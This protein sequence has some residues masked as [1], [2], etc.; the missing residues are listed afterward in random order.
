MLKMRA[1]VTAAIATI[2]AVPAIAQERRPGPY[3]GIHPGATLTSP[4][5]A[6]LTG[7]SQPTRCDSLLYSNGVPVATDCP[8]SSPREIY[9]TDFDLGTGYIGSVQ[10]GYGW[11]RLRLEAEYVVRF[12]GSSSAP[13][14][15]TSDFVA[16]GKAREWNE[17]APPHARVS[18]LRAHQIFANIYYDFANASRWTPYAGVGAGIARTS[19]AYGNRYVR[20]TLAQGFHPTGGVDPTTAAA[21]PEWQRNS[22]GTVSAIEADVSDTVLGFQLLGGLDYDLTDRVSVGAQVRWSRFEPIT[23]E[24]TWDL[25]RSHAP[26]LADGV[27]PYVLGLEVD[28]MQ[29]LALT[30][31]IKVRF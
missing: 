7:N 25:V 5:S 17:A 30:A 18:D 26:V 3:V 20:K 16:S 4:L 12:E 27:T 1:V 21:I 23:A 19:L 2:V 24:L 9:S 6:P 14:Y 13:I 15:A 22:A 10:A 11:T 28:G 29:H 31:G 8:P